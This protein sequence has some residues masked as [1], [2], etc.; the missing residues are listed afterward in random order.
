MLLKREIQALVVGAGPVGLLTALSL[1]RRGVEVAVIDEQH[2]TAARTYACAL[3]PRSLEILE[4]AGVLAELSERGQRLDVVAY[5]DGSARQA[6][7]KLADAGGKYPYLLAVP[8]QTLEDVLEERLRAEGVRVHWSHRL[9]GFH[10]EGVDAR[11]RLERLEKSTAGYGV[12]SS[13]W[14]V[15]EEGEARVALVV[16][17]DGHRSRVRR[18]SGI[19]LAPAGA[20]QL[21]AVWEF[22][23]EGPELREARI[24]LE[25]GK[26]TVLWPLGQGWWRLGFEIDHA[27][28]YEERREKSRVPALAGDPTTVRLDPARLGE[29]A[30]QRAPWLESPP[31]EVSWSM[32]LRFERRLATAFGRGS[33]W[34][35]GDAAHLA[36]PIGVHSLNAGLWEA[37]TLAAEIDAVLRG[38]AARARLEA[39][40]EARRSE[41]EALLSAPATAA[42]GA[43]GFV[44]AHAQAITDSLPLSGEARGRA[45]RALGLQGAGEAPA[46]A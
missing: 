14:V 16:G 31:R 15:A 17:A 28:P 23:A 18:A 29:L 7:V 27:G 3:H 33:A 5:Y 40:G 42:P 30:A 46:S 20:A 39:W 26:W 9:A 25:G 41:F 34:L 45:L 10:E 43:G 22:A 32:A 8:Q 24:S 11:V 19:E 13:G 1:A 38:G 2:R 44:G 37:S 6:E 4:E 21:F 12:P 36:G 35:V